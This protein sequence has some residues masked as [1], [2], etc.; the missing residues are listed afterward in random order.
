MGYGE[1]LKM[2]VSNEL[3]RRRR[4]DMPGPSGP[5]AAAG[6]HAT[7]ARRDFAGGYGCGGGA[8]R[9]FL[10][11]AHRT[12][13]P[14]GTHVPEAAQEEE[15]EAEEQEKVRTAVNVVFRK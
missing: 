6:P 14:T 12:T 4:R 9:G 5:V 3:W 8:H 7:G 2:S 11:C 15:L 13:A 1:P 10:G